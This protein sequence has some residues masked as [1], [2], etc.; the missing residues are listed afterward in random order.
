MRV[1]EKV[2]RIKIEDH[3]EIYEYGPQL[4]DIKV[5]YSGFMCRNIR[6][7]K[8]IQLLDKVV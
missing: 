6:S 2:E 3:S 5:K 1:L 8:T 4:L 7:Q